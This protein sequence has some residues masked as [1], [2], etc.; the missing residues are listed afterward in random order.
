MGKKLAEKV[1]T[2]GYKPT[3]IIGLARGGWIPSRL[4][5]DFLVITYLISRKVE[6]WLQTG[7]TKDEAT[8]RYP[9]SVDL[10]MKKLLIIDDIADTG[11]S[12]LTS[13]AHV[14]QLHPSALR[15][16]TMQYIPQSAFKPDYYA[17]EVKIWTW[18]IYPWNWIED[19]STLI[20]RLMKINPDTELTLL[21]LEERLESLFE[22]KWQKKMLDYILT[23]M[24]E[25]R[26]IKIKKDRAKHR[27]KLRIERVIEL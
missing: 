18:F 21:D 26:Q 12:L 22:I 15:V 2:S 1:K 8:I 24:A 27:Y 16:A 3:T 6:H 9:L 19:T 11:K 5:C 23:V 20:I 25:R 4:M 14:N 10:R 7:R 17:E 13:V